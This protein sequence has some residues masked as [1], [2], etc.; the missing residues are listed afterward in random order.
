MTHSVTHEIECSE[1]DGAGFMMVTRCCG[2]ALQCGACCGNGIDDQDPCITCQGTGWRAMT[3]D[4][5][6]D[7]AE[8]AYERQME[9]YYGGSSP[10]TLDEQHRAAWKQKQELRR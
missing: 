7:A 10:V 2:Y 8:R 3:P 5:E 6:A 4:E 9:D 1:C